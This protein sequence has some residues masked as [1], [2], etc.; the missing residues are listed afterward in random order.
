MNELNR[1]NRLRGCWPVV[2][3]F[4]GALSGGTML[5]R[6]VL[7]WFNSYWA[8]C[9]AWT[10]CTC[11]VLGSL[12]TLGA[13]FSLPRRTPWRQAHM[14]AV[15]SHSTSAAPCV[16][17][18][19]HE[20]QTRHAASIYGRCAATCIATTS[21]GYIRS[22]FCQ[23]CMR[24]FRDATRPLHRQGGCDADGLTTC[25]PLQRCRR[26]RCSSTS[27]YSSTTGYTTAHVSAEI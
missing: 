18:A 16:C 6:G 2:K 3:P 14:H 23:Y 11:C 4:A 9:A 8:Q 26:S 13:L 19:H 1:Y 17:L 10:V 12:A 24:M 22:L 27:G 20:R 21:C 25:V 15:H 5:W 7:H